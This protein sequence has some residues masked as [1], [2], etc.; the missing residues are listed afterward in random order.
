LT[1]RGLGEREMVSQKDMKLLCPHCGWWNPA[2]IDTG[3]TPDVFYC[4]RCGKNVPS[5]R[6]RSASAPAPAKGPYQKASQSVITSSDTNVPRK[7]V[8]QSAQRGPQSATVSPQPAPQ[9]YPPSF[10][11]TLT[12]FVM[13]VIGSIIALIAMS[14]ARHY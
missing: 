11:I 10:W 3:K 2:G 14:A 9:L 1:L 7:P 4:F 12:V 5:V 6:S 8:H 13:L